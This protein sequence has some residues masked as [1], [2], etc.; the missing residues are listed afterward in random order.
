[1]PGH[2]SFGGFVGVDMVVPVWAG[3][4]RV[5]AG[6]GTST[7]PRR[8]RDSGRDE[9]AYFIFLLPLGQAVGLAQYS[10]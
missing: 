4:G 5:R 8:G 3:R 7:R 1:L 9:A 10:D 6:P 2:L